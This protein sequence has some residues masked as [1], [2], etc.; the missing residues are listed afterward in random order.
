MDEV[1][2]FE[3]FPGSRRAGDWAASRIRRVP[4]LAWPF[5]ALAG[6]DFIVVALANGTNWSVLGF[7]VVV[8]RVA[9]ALLPAAVII[10]CPTAWRTARLVL[11]GAIAWSTIGAAATLL[12][13]LPFVSTDMGLH[14]NYASLGVSF[15]REIA[16]LAA[17]IA[18]VMGLSVRRRTSTSWPVPVVIL[19]LAGT[20]LALVYV[21]SNAWSSYN[22]WPPLFGDSAAQQIQL[23]LQL[24]EPL[25]LPVF[26]ALAWSSLSAVRAGEERPRFWAALAGGSALLLVVYVVSLVSA[27]A[28]GVIGY[29]AGAT[30][31]YA[32]LNYVLTCVSVVG[33]GLLLLAFALGLPD[34][35]MDLGD[36]QEDAGATGEAAA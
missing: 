26:G 20:T 1:P 36:V 17:P 27:W 32:N 30:D 34:D 2:E 4:A 31:L 3:L 18:I 35:P 22:D 29:S 14:S 10:G 33:I 16:S 13:G 7:L 6:L 9:W 15:L 8:Y 21:G 23:V 25:T 11:V 12:W 5:I 24:L 28:F 19:G